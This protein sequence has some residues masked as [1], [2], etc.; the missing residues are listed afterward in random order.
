MLLDLE[1]HE[2]PTSKRDDL[3]ETSKSENDFIISRIEMDKIQWQKKSKLVSIVK[4]G[5]LESPKWLPQ[6]AQFYL[7]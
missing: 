1:N 7:H 5:Q 4:I 2:T 6:Q 3:T